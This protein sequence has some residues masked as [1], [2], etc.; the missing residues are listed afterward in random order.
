MLNLEMVMG[1]G[2]WG[3]PVGVLSPGQKGLE[4]IFF[5]LAFVVFT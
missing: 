3:M 4:R 2:C 1:K 5:V